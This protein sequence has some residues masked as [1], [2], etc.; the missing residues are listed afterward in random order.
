MPPTTISQLVRVQPTRQKMNNVPL[1]RIDTNTYNIAPSYNLISPTEPHTPKGLTKKIK[2][3]SVANKMIELDRNCSGKVFY[4]STEK[5]RC[6][7]CKSKTSYFCLGCKQ[8][9]CFNKNQSTDMSK[10]KNF[11]YSTVSVC[12]KEKVFQVCC[13]QKKHYTK[14][15][16]SIL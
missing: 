9:F 10:V 13:F 3:G 2:N 16:D 4:T 11:S 15:D 1:G 5:Q 7:M 12:G 6:S 8:W 14:R